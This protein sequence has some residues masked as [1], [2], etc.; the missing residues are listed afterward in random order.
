MMKPN[1]LTAN[2][3]LLV[4]VMTITGG[5]TT[6]AVEPTEQLNL[7]STPPLQEKDTTSYTDKVTDTLGGY[8]DE[9]V[10]FLTDDCGVGAYSMATGKTVTYGLVGSLWGAGKATM[11][12][13]VRFITR[14]R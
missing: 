14:T 5:C 7:S 1:R 8:Y 3:L 6:D 2:V 9:T 13:T 4:G 12:G 10:S 11:Y